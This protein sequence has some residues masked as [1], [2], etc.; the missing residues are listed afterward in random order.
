M[1]T[2]SLLLH[3][4]FIIPKN[5]VYNIGVVKLYDIAMYKGV[6][7]CFK[8]SSVQHSAAFD[9]LSAFGDS[10]RLPATQFY[11]VSTGDGW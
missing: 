8:L 2:N 5:Y 6:G 10:Q 4:F 11:P 7:G 9:N 1:E 3:K